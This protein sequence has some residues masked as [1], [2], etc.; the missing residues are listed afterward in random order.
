MALEMKPMCELC[1]AS[2]GASDA[3]WIS[4]P[5]ARAASAR[6]SIGAPRK[7]PRNCPWK[8]PKAAE[9]VWL[10]FISVL[11]CLVLLECNDRL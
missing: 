10:V 1:A 4:V 3:A 7:R 5:T 6:S 9:R 8:C 2:L 11:Y